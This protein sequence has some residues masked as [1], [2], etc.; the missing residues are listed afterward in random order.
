V[1]V[2]VCVCVYR[3]ICTLLRLSVLGS[4]K[5]LKIAAFRKRVYEDRESKDILANLRNKNGTKDRKNRVPKLING[6]E[7]DPQDEADDVAEAA[8]LNKDKGNNYETNRHKTAD[9]LADE[10]MMNNNRSSKSRKQS[11]AHAGHAH[12][13]GGAHAA[14][15]HQTPGMPIILI[16]THIIHPRTVDMD[17]GAAMLIAVWVTVPHT[18]R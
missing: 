10:E 1:C 14:P 8:V 5:W 3:C 9:Q 7:K 2:C 4:K 17:M 16:Q 11:N 18:H 6:K 13:R 12:G 15:Q